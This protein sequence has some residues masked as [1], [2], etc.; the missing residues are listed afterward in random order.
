[1]IDLISKKT[2]YR[3]LYSVKLKTVLYSMMLFM[4]LVFLGVHLY[5]VTNYSAFIDDNDY[6]LKSSVINA[7]VWERL[8]AHHYEDTRFVA[9]SLASD[10]LFLNSFVTEDPEEINRQLEGAVYKNFL[11]MNELG[12]LEMRA[13]TSDYKLLGTWKSEEAVP[14]SIEK[15]L[16]QQQELP[17]TNQLKIQSHFLNSED[18]NPVHLLIL[19][20]GVVNNFGFLVLLTSPLASLQGMGEFIN[21]DVE[22]KN[23]HGDIIIASDTFGADFGAGGQNIPS[24][25][26][27][28][29]VP[30]SFN[31]GEPF[32][33]VVISYDNSAAL[34]YQGK[35]YAFSILTAIVSLLISLYIVSYVLNI[36]M[37]RRIR[38]ISEIM[39]K[40]V[41]GQRE[42]IL[43]KAR[44]DE[45]SIIR[46][47][48][49]K[50]VVY[51]EDRSRLNE[52][53][54]IARKEAEVSNVAKA[55]FLANMSHE[56]RTP[57]NAII[58]FSEILS[59]DYM[60]RGLEQK[61]REYAQ[62]IRD[63]GVHLL[64]IIN[65]ILDL[66]KIE[67]GNMIL[68][69]EEIAVHDVVGKSVKFIEVMAKDKSITIKNNIPDNLPH[70]YGDE[71]MVR[72]ILLNIL[73]NAVKF[74]PIGGNVLINATIETDGTF[75]IT[76]SDNGIGIGEDYI[77]KVVSPFI[78]VDSSYTREQEGTGL[79]LAL[80]KA[81][82]ELHGGKVCLEST[83]GVGTTIYL[84]FPNTCL[85]R[86]LADPGA[87]NQ[88]GRTQP[89][90]SLVN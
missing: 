23:L 42:V 8:I 28:V 10:P 47:Q 55:E 13:L 76:V 73:S 32:L 70:L 75:C 72:Q 43:P 7:L 77:E 35:L 45:L 90:L 3:L 86:D 66:S 62:D 80:V 49:E 64:N 26:T 88:S 69:V 6:K 37:F 40:I 87:L 60:A 85:I 59:S 9:E 56:L 11:E 16:K 53:L 51:E 31:D 2:L 48:L 12:A 50:V 71:R 68:S 14:I 30:I 74:T 54:I 20:I 46:E 57:L 82:M 4:G 79:G 15:I 65:D 29:E 41:Q 17:Y 27:T 84:I 1:M 39:A 33:N 63:S 5:T 44:D 36:S 78:Q 25:F 24:Y 81:F 34:D 52:E 58:G 21:A 67:A 22:V 89:D 18:G 61:Y 38:E 19:P 83:L